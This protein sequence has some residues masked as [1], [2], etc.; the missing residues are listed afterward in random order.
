VTVSLQQ[1]HRR[2]HEATTGNIRPCAV[3]VSNIRQIHDGTSMGIV[4]LSFSETETYMRNHY[5]PVL[6]SNQAK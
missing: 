2:I 4:E 3:V 6:I 5:L 1:Q